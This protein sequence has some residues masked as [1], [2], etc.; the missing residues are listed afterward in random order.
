MVPDERMRKWIK[1]FESLPPDAQR[2]ELLRVESESFLPARASRV[3]YC[4]DLSRVSASRPSLDPREDRPTWDY[5][6]AGS[7]RVTDDVDDGMFS[8]LELSDKAR[9]LVKFI[10]ER[11]GYRCAQ[12]AV[13][14]M[15]GC[16]TGAEIGA[17]M[18]VVRQTADGHLANIQ[19][20]EVRRKAIEL[21]LVT[22]KSFIKAAGLMPKSAGR[23]AAK[24]KVSVK[25][26]GG[27]R[28]VRARAA[29]A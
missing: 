3:A 12:A 19:S 14:V 24:K 1:K 10:R 8:S 11:F 18:G 16:Y 2:A 26:L 22:R 29:V 9:E 5:S 6:V 7:P 21:G 28:A 27:R 23:P 20:P 17:N 15:H 4:P 25:K 13:A